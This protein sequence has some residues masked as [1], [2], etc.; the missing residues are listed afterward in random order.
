MTGCGGDR[1]V[2]LRGGLAVGLTVGAVA[3]AGCA[4]APSTQPDHPARH[5]MAGRSSPVV[6]AMSPPSPTSLGVHASPDCTPTDL[7]MQ[8]EFG[9]IGAGNAIGMVLV[10]DTAPWP[11]TVQGQV[12]VTGVG[13]S[14]RT[15]TSSVTYRLSAP[16]VLSAE[17]PRLEPGRPLP[18]SALVLSLAI[19]AE[20]RDD[21][22]EPDGLCTRHSV[23]PT[24][25]R[26]D[27]MGKTYHVGNA[28]ADGQMPTC[29]GRIAARPASLH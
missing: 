28:S 7:N 4:P 18:L 8:F 19:V 21:P 25:W 17:T 3:L 10:R 15:V 2:T 9:G 13:G 24:T 6:T 14:G 5:S 23:V 26:V 1:S 12:R 16:L 29:R 20:Y 11:C 27:L 22:T